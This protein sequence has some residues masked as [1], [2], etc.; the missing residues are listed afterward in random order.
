MAKGA[1]ERA[2]WQKAPSARQARP[3]EEQ[4]LPLMVAAG[5]AGEDRVQVGY[6]GTLVE[7][8]LSAFHFG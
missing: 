3:P 6:R 7:L 5:E 4:L 2:R 8:A 1:P